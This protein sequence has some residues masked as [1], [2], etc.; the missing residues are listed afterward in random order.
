[1]LI[2]AK[3][4]EV[5]STT[6]PQMAIPQI[7]SSPNFLP[8]LKARNEKYKKRAKRAMEI[9]SGIEGIQVVEPKG[10]FYLT[11]LFKEGVLN[12]KM[13]LE[14]QNPQAKEYIEELVKTAANDRRFVLYLLGAKGIC[15]VPLTSFY[16]TKDGFRITLLEEN[17]EV[18]EY[19][20]QTV[21]NA[22]REYI[23]SA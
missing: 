16:C 7:Y 14:I 21:A 3:M 4:L 2:D 1:S 11:V 10:G 8:H 13:K 9:F 18:F 15:V 6:L 12:Q 17:E 22:I 19:T 5:C 20:F 23:K